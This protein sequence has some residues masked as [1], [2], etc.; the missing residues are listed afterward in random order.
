MEW[1]TQPSFREFCMFVL[2]GATSCISAFLCDS[3]LNGEAARA[4]YFDT[5]LD[6]GGT[7]C[8]GTSTEPRTIRRILAQSLGN[9]A[10]LTTQASEGT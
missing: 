7:A 2:R 4:R 6:L 9:V 10:K 8:H 3:T 5:K 1:N